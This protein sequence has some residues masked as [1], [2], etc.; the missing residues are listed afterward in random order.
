MTGRAGRTMSIDS[1]TR[2]VS[3]AIKA[4]NSPK[5][6]F[7]VLEEVILL[8]GYKDSRPHSQR[9]YRRPRRRCRDPLIA[10][11]RPEQRL[12]DSRG[13]LRAT[14]GA[15]LYDIALECAKEVNVRLQPLR[16]V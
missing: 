4:T 16:P 1:A 12:H 6:I 2:A 11:S 5:P 13:F 7:D 15:V 14:P 10:A 8:S 9:P 3:V